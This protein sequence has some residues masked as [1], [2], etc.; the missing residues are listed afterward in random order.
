M[1]VVHLAQA[2]DGGLVAV[3]VLNPRGD[4]VNGRRRLAREVETMRRVRSP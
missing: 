3:K 2:P 1:G 4:D